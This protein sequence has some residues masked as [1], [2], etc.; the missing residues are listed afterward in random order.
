MADI[1]D[2][3]TYKS[4]KNVLSVTR[5]KQRKQQKNSF[6]YTVAQQFV[7]LIKLNPQS[8]IRMEH[9]LKSVGDNTSPEMFY[10]IGIAQLLINVGAGLVLMFLSPIIT[11]II[12]VIACVGFFNYLGKPEKIVKSRRG[13]IER[14]LPAFASVIEQELQKS[15]NV[16]EILE[17]YK[18]YAGP[19]LEDELHLTIAEM[20]IGNRE[21]ALID[22]ESRVG[23]TE[24]SEITRG[25][26]GVI[27]G[28]DGTI[29]FK[30]LSHQFRTLEVAKL[31]KA[32]LKQPEKI[33]KYSFLIL[34]MA[35]ATVLTV[36]GVYIYDMVKD[37]F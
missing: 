36:L 20:R 2:V 18:K 33:N 31:R 16:Q 13:K 8:K 26:I 4:I 24:L 7:G 30:M 34:M 25:L 23:S 29:Y 28:D 15:R 5:G 17:Y 9:I 1:F 22:L 6:Y 11:V 21:K 3:P 35:I 12:S 14:E 32:I 19:E 37:L 10:A 27:R